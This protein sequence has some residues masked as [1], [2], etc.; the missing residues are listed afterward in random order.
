MSIFCLAV[1]TR[2]PLYLFFTPFDSDQVDKKGLPEKQVEMPLQSL[3]H[4]SIV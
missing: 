2:F 4:L 3:T 1:L